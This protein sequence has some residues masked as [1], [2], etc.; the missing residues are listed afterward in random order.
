MRIL[1]LLLLTLLPGFAAAE[2]LSLGRA[3][4]LALDNNLHMKLAR[5]DG[6]TARAEALSRASRLLP[7]AYF[8]AS[9]S[10]TFRENLSSIG[11]GAP[12]GGP[13][14]IG[15]FDTFD[16]RL[17]LVQSLLDLPSANSARSGAEARRAADLKVQLASE[18]VSAA[19]A[20]AYLDVLRSSA[21]LNSASAGFELAGSLRSL[22][23]NKHDAGTATGL[24]V[25]RARTREAEEKLRVSRVST[26]LDDAWLRLKRLLGLPFGRDLRLTE[27]L[28]YT[29]YETPEAG[30]AVKEALSGRLEIQ[31]AAAALSASSYA[32]KAAR[33]A[34][35]PALALSGSA[36]MSGNKPDGNA[37]LVGDMGL[38]LKMPLYAGGRVSAGVDAALS[39]RERAESLYA[40]ASAMAEQET[41]SALSRLSAADEEVATASM[42]VTMASQELEMARN[43]FAAGAGDNIELVEAQTS[44]S[45][46]RDALVDALSRGKEA[47]IRLTL[48]LGRMKDLKF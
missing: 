10:R 43:R 16:A 9:Q 40:D 39:A 41:L 23:E 12:G 32:L 45:R 35:L 5:A 19:A 3:V 14:L 25:L 6:E 17:A 26:A 22:A 36:A 18:Q 11:F 13:N 38:S 2:D 15:P 28:A 48:A 30:A 4:N 27:D 7:Q 47:N 1:L 34:R 42:T 46:A 8:S 44:L 29:S 31:I 24:D 33:G 20:L 37:R 21:A